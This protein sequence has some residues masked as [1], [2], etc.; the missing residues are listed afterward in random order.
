MNSDPI[1]S[2]ARLRA[3]RAASEAEHG[4]AAFKAAVEALARGE[5]V[6]A[7]QLDG[8]LRISGRTVDD[9]RAAVDLKRQ[10]DAAEADASTPEKI[11]DLHARLARADRLFFAEVER[12]KERG[13]QNT[14]VWSLGGRII[15]VNAD[16]LQP[17]LA[18]MERAE[19]A[20]NDA[21]AAVARR[22]SL[23]QQLAVVLGDAEAPAPQ[24][25][26]REL[27]VTSRKVGPPLARDERLRLSR[28]GIT[29]VKSHE[30]PTQKDPGDSAQIHVVRY[31]KGKQ[32]PLDE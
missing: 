11:D 30:V 1:A 5:D 20:W 26:R 8:A 24:Q 25:E 32:V 22:D 18:T 7:D 19:K 16:S 9:L 4:R 31:V 28:T 15:K 2:L 13:L 27:V 6:A 14:V 12:L 10:L 17:L 29:R 23:R 3:D 21:R